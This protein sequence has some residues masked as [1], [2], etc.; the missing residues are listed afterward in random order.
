[1]KKTIL[2]IIL[3]LSVFLSAC[4]VT[5]EETKNDQ[6]IDVQQAISSKTEIDKGTSPVKEFNIISR[7]YEF[8]PNTLIVNQG[9][10]VV[11]EIISMDVE[12]GFAIDEYNINE[13]IP[14]GKTMVI[15]FLANKSGEF[16]FYC[17]VYCGRGHTGMI[18]KLI[19]E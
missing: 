1:M 2:S 14:E 9:D 19:V 15:E 11:I 5:E 7:Q 8:E 3:I 10:K 12:H 4:A 13:V 6:E 18:G 17:S 16:E